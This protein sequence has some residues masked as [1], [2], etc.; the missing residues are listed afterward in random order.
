MAAGGQSDWY[1]E[2]GADIKLL[3]EAIEKWEPSIA[4]WVEEVDDAV[5]SFIIAVLKEARRNDSFWL[6]G[7]YD[8]K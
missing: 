8:D 7:L 4:K 2:F 3:D 6:K 5:K 1:D